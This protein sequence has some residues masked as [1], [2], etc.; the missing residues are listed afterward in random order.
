MQVQVCGLYNTSPPIE[1]PQPILNVQRIIFPG[2]PDDRMGRKYEK[3]AKAVG[4]VGNCA[5][6]CVLM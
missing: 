5:S 4:F 1:L 2:T 6:S 3:G